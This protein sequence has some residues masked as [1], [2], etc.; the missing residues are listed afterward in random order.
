ME[1]LVPCYRWWEVVYYGAGTKIYDRIAGKHNF[2]RSKFRSA[3]DAVGRW[4]LLQQKDLKGAIVYADGQFDDARFAVA[5]VQTL[6]EAGGEAANHARVVNLRKDTRGKIVEA[7]IEDQIS[8]SVAR[9]AFASEQR[10]S[11]PAASRW[12]YEGRDGRTQDR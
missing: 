4:P 8:E 2:F 5:L 1:F 7:E 9:E 3:R 6:T 12:A 11:Y 10:Y